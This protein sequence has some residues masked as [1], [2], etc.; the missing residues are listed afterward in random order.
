[1]L[2]GP[3]HFSLRGSD[4]GV[5]KNLRTLAHAREGQA[6]WRAQRDDFLK[7]PLNPG[8]WPRGP[9]L[10]ASTARG[11]FY[12]RAENRPSWDSNSRPRGSDATGLASQLGCPT[13]R[14]FLQKKMQWG[15]IVARVEA[16]SSFFLVW[17]ADSCYFL[18]GS[19]LLGR[20]S[21]TSDQVGL[22]FVV[23]GTE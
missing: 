17:S 11:F 19:F 10:A 7:K 3:H 4:F 22:S 5:E 23:S 6:L 13:F 2:H 21:F 12:S 15:K 20:L 1:M 14:G 16:A 9:S 8:P 18:K